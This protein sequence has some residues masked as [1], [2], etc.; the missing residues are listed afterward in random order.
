LDSDGSTQVQWGTQT[1]GFG[2]TVPCSIAD[3]LITIDQDSTLWTTDDAQDPSPLSIFVSAW[4]LTPRGKLIQQLQIA[5]KTQFV[6]PSS[7]G[8]ATM[9]FTTWLAFSNYN[10]A[11]ALYYYN[12]NYYNAPEVDR[13]INHAFDEHPATDGDLGSVL[14]SVPATV[15]AQPVVWGAND[16]LVRDALKIQ[17]VDVVSTTPLDTQVLAYNQ[18]NNQWEPSNQAAGTGNVTSNEIVSTDG[19]VT[20]A[21]GTGGKT[22]KFSTIIDNGVSFDAT[23]MRVIAAE[24]DSDSA[25]LA[26]NGTIRLNKDDFIAWRNEANGGNILLEKD[27]SDRIASS[28]GFAGALTGNVTGDVTGNVSGTAS[29]LSGT[30][31]LPNGTTATTQTPSDNSTKLATTAYVDAAI[32]VGGGYTTVEDEGTPLT[33]RSTMNFVGAG[34]TAADSGA[35]TTITIPGG[36]GTSSFASVDKFSYN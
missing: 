34:V 23:G 13:L 9:P 15:P 7:Q 3:G 17:G 21:S 20:L 11:V 2:I 25:N 30:P 24:Y 31:A 33:Q 36:S 27:A 22:I 35:V 1:S 19:Q 8:I 5:G 12:P 16:P 26:D 29:N 32:P 28:G 6:V 14:L 4:L 18:S 10:Q